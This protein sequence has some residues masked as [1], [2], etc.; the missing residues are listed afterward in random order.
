MFHAC[1]YLALIHTVV[2][3]TGRRYATRT[4][5]HEEYIMKQFSPACISVDEEV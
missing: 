1:F 3:N 2:L 5:E 4:G